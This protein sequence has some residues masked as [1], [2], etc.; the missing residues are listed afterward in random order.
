MTSAFFAQAAARSTQPG[1]ILQPYHTGEPYYTA[2]Q[3]NE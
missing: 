1:Q 2:E 3:G